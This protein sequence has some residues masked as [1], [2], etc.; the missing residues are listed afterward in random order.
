ALAALALSGLALTTTGTPIAVL[1]AAADPGARG[2][3]RPRQRDDHR[4]AR[5]GA[6][7]PG[8]RDHRGT[9]YRDNG[10]LGHR[11]GVRRAVRGGD[12]PRSAWP[13]PRDGRARHD[14]RPRS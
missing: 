6:P 13:G 2:G 9:F 1:L 10:N 11:R 3:I 7:R 14:L 8:H 4:P 12:G 5:R